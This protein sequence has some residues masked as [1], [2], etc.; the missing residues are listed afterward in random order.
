MTTTSTAASNGSTSTAPAETATAE[1]ERLSG[2]ARV[3]EAQTYHTVSVLR[4]AMTEADRLCDQ[5]HHAVSGAYFKDIRQASA[6]RDGRTARDLA[7]SPEIRGQAEEALNCLYTA[8]NYLNDL[9]GYAS[10]PPF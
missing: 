5:I 2:M 8:R 3:R 10:E 1:P 9:L 6:P 7:S 4:D